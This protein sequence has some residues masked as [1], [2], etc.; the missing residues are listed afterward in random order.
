MLNLSRLNIAFKTDYIRERFYYFKL[1]R[2]S[3]QGVGRGFDTPPIIPLEG[4]GNLAS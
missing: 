2:G 3:K 1:F 4:I